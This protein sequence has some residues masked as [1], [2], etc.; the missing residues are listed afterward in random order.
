MICYTYDALGN[1]TGKLTHIKH[2]ALP[3]RFTTEKPPNGEYPVWVGKW[4][5]RDAPVVPPEPS[6]P[7]QESQERLRQKA[8]KEESDPLFFQWQA[9]ENTEAQWLAKREEIRLRYPY[10]SV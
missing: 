4:E 8:Y 2:Q 7:T 5:L 6:A 3:K 10:P 1:Y 9:G